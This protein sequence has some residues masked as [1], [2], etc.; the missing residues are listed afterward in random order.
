MD[1]PL[2]Q[3]PATSERVGCMD[4]RFEA[5]EILRA[6]GHRVTDQRLKILDAMAE[7][8]GHKTL[9]QIFACLKSPVDRSTLYRT[10]D[11]FENLGLVVSAEL[12]DGQRVYEL[13]QQSPHH[14]LVCQGCQK[15]S[16]LS[17]NVLEELALIVAEE[18]DFE[19]NMDHL[20]VFGFCSD[21][22]QA[23]DSTQGAPCDPSS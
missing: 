9:G 19:I 6:H 12:G 17:H 21:C 2:L 22:Q 7:S 5:E 11:L 4:R 15:V 13:A 3:K 23:L 18:H 1:L 20:V 14:H 8:P 10:L 16:D